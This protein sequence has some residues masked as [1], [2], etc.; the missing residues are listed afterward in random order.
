MFHTTPAE[1]STMHR[2]SGELAGQPIGIRS[3]PAATRGRIRAVPHPMQKPA[4]VEVLVL[5]QERA[6]PSRLY[7][8]MNPGESKAMRMPEPS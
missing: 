5:L 8:R 1:L 2:L 6:D 3:A 7:C 4:A